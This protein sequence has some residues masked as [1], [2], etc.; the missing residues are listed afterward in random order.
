MI[1]MGSDEENI[2]CCLVKWLT[3]ESTSNLFCSQGHCQKVSSSQTSETVAAE[4]EPT[5]G[6]GSDSDEW[7]VQ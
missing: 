5:Q 1:I 3:D 7:G 4:F 6:N 2:S